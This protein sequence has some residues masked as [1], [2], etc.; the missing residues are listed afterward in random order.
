VSDWTDLVA[1]VARRDPEAEVA[2]FEHFGP[3]VLF[4]ASR[5]L[6][7]AT[8]AEDVRSE[9]M[10]RVLRAIIDD[11]VHTPAALPGFVLQVARNVIHE[12]QRDERR[13]LPL[14]AAPDPAVSP[15][16][17]GCDPGARRALRMAVA[18]LGA[19]DRAFLRMYFVEDLSRGE[20]ARRLGI[21]EERVRLVKSRA[22]QR[23][24]AAY[25]RMIQP[26]ASGGG[27]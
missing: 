4:L 9:T 13:Q 21:A 5:T 22:V 12:R 3:R 16:V 10:V 23:F 20:I 17:A 19:R 1:R 2:L 7:S 8:G 18:D 11:R 26:V 27:Q 6:G 14:D 25:H 15:S 24:R